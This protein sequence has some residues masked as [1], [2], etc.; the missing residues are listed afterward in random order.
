MRLIC[1]DGLNRFFAFNVLSAEAMLVGELM[2]S[3]S[4]YSDWLLRVAKAGFDL[5]LNGI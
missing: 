2:A 4:I 3:S 1:C 5:W